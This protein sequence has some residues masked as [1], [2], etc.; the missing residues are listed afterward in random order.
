MEAEKRAGKDAGK[1]PCRGG[2]GKARPEQK[3]NKKKG[4]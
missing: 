1:P 2:G 3:R 4:K